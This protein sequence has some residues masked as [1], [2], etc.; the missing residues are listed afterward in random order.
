MLELAFGPENFG[1]PRDEIHGRITEVL[2]TVHLEGFEKRQPYTL[3]GGQKQRLAI[4][5]VLATH[6]E[7]ICM[8]EP[9]TDL[10]P[11]G[12]ME[13]FTIARNLH[14]DSDFT[15]LIIEHE[16]EEALHADR[17]ILMDNGIILSDGKP[18]NILRD[19]ELTDKIGIQSL[20]IPKFFKSYLNMDT[21]ELPLSPEEGVI[22]FK[23]R[24]LSIDE[25]AYGT[26]LLSDT[27]KESS[28][29]DL[30]IEVKTLFIFT[31]IKT[32]LWMESIFKS[33][34]EN[35]SRFLVTTAAGRQLWSNILTDCY[36]P[37]R[38]CNCRWKEY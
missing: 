24:N 28:Y 22:E 9:T 26:L 36:F 21:L 3:S 18:E 25:D 16:T 33:E 20:Q 38:G 34:K 35:S 10:D 12:K 31:I 7:I 32:K 6:P 29:G 13:I 4:G 30:F 14:A 19:V 2:K 37:L 11:V 17:L 5:S 1:V 23:K 15:L 8:D 27:E